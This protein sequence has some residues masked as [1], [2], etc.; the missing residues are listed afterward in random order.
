MRTV[1]EFTKIVEE[2]NKKHNEELLNLSPATLIARAWEI[3]EWQAIYDYMEG[4]VIPYLEDGEEMFEDF[5]KFEYRTPIAEIYTYECRYDEPQWT[6]WDSLDDVVREMFRETTKK[7]K[8]D[9]KTMKQQKITRKMIEKAYEEGLIKII[10]S[11]HD[12]GAVCKI[13]EYWFYFGGETAEEMT[14]SE[15]VSNVPKEDIIN[16]ITTVLDDFYGDETFE[17]EYDYYFAI[18]NHN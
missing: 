18:I 3:A 10:D 1:E 16:E 5:L 9:Y 11:P 4:K 15:Y 17:D 13:G 7:I 14:A 12:D 8:G 6:T 2:E